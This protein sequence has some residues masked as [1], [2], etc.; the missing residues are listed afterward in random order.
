MSTHMTIFRKA[1]RKP[2]TQD[3]FTLIEVMI[4]VAVIGIL[5]AVAY[6][7][8]Q[9]YVVRSYRASAKSCMMEHSQFMER[10]YTTAL[11]YGSDADPQP[12]LGC[13]NEGNLNT[14]YTITVGGRAQGTYTVTATPI[15]PQL[16]NDTR[17][18]TL[19]INQAGTR[20]ESG[21]GTVA[22]CW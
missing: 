8:Y 9:D 11:S 7:S 22:D 18:G 19:T 10:R 21:T 6:P 17:C 15:G 13:R 12:G 1:S 14:R 16:A 3:G 5:A 4:V 20:T 2:S